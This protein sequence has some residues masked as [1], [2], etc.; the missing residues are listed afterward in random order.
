MT[1]TRTH[2]TFRVDTWTPDGESM[3]DTRAASGHSDCAAERGYQIL[4][5]NRDWHVNP[6]R[7][8]WLRRI[9]RRDHAVLPRVGEGVQLWDLTVAGRA[10]IGFLRPCGFSATH[11]KGVLKL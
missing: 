9:S 2:F 11:P 4:P 8:G 6:P 7:E 3:V 1:T 5:S 10:V